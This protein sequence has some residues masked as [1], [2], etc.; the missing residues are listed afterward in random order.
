M[1]SF[2]AYFSQLCGGNMAY[3]AKI[4]IIRSLMSFIHASSSSMHISL[5]LD[6]KENNHISFLSFL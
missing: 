4:F 2:M 5:I 3:K 1:Y 6:P